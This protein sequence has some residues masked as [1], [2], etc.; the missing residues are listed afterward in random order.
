MACPR[1]GTNCLSLIAHQSLHLIVMTAP[2]GFTG[3]VKS[4]ANHLKK[5]MQ[6][7]ISSK[8]HVCKMVL[9][10]C[11]VVLLRTPRLWMHQYDDSPS[12]HL[13]W[14]NMNL[15][16]ESDIEQKQTVQ[17]AD[18]GRRQVWGIAVNNLTPCFSKF[19]L[20]LRREINNLCQEGWILIYLCLYCCTK[21][22]CILLLEIKQMQ[23]QWLWNGNDCA[24]SQVSQCDCHN[25]RDLYLCLR[26]H[27]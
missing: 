18:C 19:R 9:W 24:T 4:V 6:F 22:H 7:L 23:M 20:S 1:P 26:Q 11:T 27:W 10:T 2:N 17:P 12:A 5:Q 16:L 3:F 13:N 8:M 14:A 25:S 15:M 21:R